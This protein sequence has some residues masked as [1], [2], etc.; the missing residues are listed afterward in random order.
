MNWFKCSQYENFVQKIKYILKSNDFTKALADYYHIPISDID[1]HMDIK[2]CS[3]D[4]QYAEGNGKQIK[5]DHKLLNSDFFN[6]N[7]HFIIH[8]YF[9]WLKRRSEAKFYL[10]DPEEVQSFV[11]QI[12]WQ[13]INGVDERDI[14][15][16]IYPIIQTHY[17]EESRAAEVF[18]QM[19]EKAKELAVIYEKKVKTSI[20]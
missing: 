17:D 10:N 20:K 7:F 14:V 12:V 4:G 6:E 3:L 19:M 16:E 5:I 8:E 11:L 15:H 18:K 13:L 1:E 2:I 9:H